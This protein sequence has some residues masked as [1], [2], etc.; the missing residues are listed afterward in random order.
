MIEVLFDI[1]QTYVE[2]GELCHKVTPLVLYSKHCANLIS[3]E[4]L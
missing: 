3:C 4:V 1:C 2:L